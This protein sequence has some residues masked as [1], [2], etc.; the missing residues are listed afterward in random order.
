MRNLSKALASVAVVA[1]LSLAAPG[2]AEARGR[3][4]PGLAGGLIAG[5]LIGGLASQAY[6]YGPGYGGGYPY[7]VSYGYGPYP[8]DAYASGYQVAYAPVYGGYG[9]GRS[10]YRPAYYAP[11][12]SHYR[13]P[14]YYSYA[15]APVVSYGYRS[16][17]YDR[18]FH[19]GWRNS[20]NHGVRNVG[21][22][23]SRYRY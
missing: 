7:G 5:A 10:Y 14:G 6:A 23:H 18:R 4:F 13:T 16:V 19:H 9:Y 3:F 2:S 11:R 22:H 15:R 12:Y 1:G 8:Y 17:R 21:Y 20:W